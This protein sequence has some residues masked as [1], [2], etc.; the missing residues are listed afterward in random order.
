MATVRL[1]DELNERAKAAAAAAGVSA[2]AFVVAAVEAALVARSE[3]AMPARQD[4]HEHGPD[5]YRRRSTVKR[6]PAQRQAGQ[7]RPERCPHPP[8][9]RIAGRCMVCGATP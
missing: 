3:A 4:K 7:Q 1:P 8:G 5:P 2:T 9:R 6:P